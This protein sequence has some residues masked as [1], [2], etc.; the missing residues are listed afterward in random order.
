M[1]YEPR[2]II[3][4]LLITVKQVSNVC[5]SSVHIKVVLFNCL[6]VFRGERELHVSSVFSAGTFIFR[7]SPPRL[8]IVSLP[9]GAEI[10]NFLKQGGI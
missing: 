3:C 1:E 10:I 4:L 8:P 5:K 7:S 6:F 2:C 9:M